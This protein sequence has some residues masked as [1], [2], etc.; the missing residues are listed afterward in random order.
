MSALV[1]GEGTGLGKALFAA[2]DGADKRALPCVSALVGGEVTGLGKALFA[3]FDGAD[4]RALPCVSALVLGEGTGFGKALFA[5]FDGADKRALPC[6]SA[7]FSRTDSECVRIRSACR[8]KLRVRLNL[9]AVTEGGIFSHR[10]V[11]EIL[12]GGRHYL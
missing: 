10:A 11:S 12:S 7:F 6:V 4:K 2:F 1:G 9:N 8:E 5:V 3:A